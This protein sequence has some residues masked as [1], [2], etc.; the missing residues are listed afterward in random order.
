VA[1]AAAGVAGVKAFGE[2]SEAISRASELVDQAAK[3]NVNTE[4]LAALR[5]SAQQSGVAIASLDKGLEMLQRRLGSGQ[6]A[7][8]LE[9]L[10]LSAEKLKEMD[11]NE[12]FLEIADSLKVVS[13]EADQAALANEIF[14]RSGQDLTNLINIG[15]EAIRQQRA[16]A[17]SLGIVL[18]EEAAAG[19]EELG[20]AQERISMAWQG[21]W[22]SMTVA[23]RDWLGALFDITAEVFT[24]GEAQTMA[25]N[26]TEM[27]LDRAN[28]EIRQ[29][30]ADQKRA[31][32]VARSMEE[33]QQRLNAE[34]AASAATLREESQAREEV[35]RATAEQQR[36]MQQ[37]QTAARETERIQA[38]IAADAKA[39]FDATRT[40]QEQLATEIAHLNE[41]LALGAIDW[42][43]YNRA[44][45]DAVRTLADAQG[46]GLPAADLSSAAPAALEKGSAGALSAVSQS[47]S[48][49]KRIEDLN[50]LSL[51]ED[52]QQ[53]RY[54][55]QIAAAAGVNSQV[56][57]F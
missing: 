3:I 52:Q 28:A 47:R 41:L 36:Q 12:A 53:T 34:S 55:Q 27:A 35:A 46:T 43:T 44:A 30:Q 13:N 29:H 26:G 4:D 32:E 25:F 9:R 54:L 33:T 5:F 20:D 57:D 1:L 18:K 2:M 14:G 19:L 31:V 23:L 6:N 40:P 38:K 8:A 50:R 21:A 11:L 16:E 10:G 56:A 42:E 39:V 51:V 48:D 15:S 22:N 37:A 49:L 17:E 45:R 24:L 7:E